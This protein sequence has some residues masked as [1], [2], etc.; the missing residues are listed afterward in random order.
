MSTWDAQRQIVPAAEW[1]GA[2]DRRYPP[3]AVVIGWTLLTGTVGL[4]ASVAWLLARNATSRARAAWTV[5]G[6]VLGAGV[7][8]GIVLGLTATAYRGPSERL[9]AA[10]VRSEVVHHFGVAVSSMTCTLPSTWSAGTT[11]TCYAYSARGLVGTSTETVAPSRGNDWY[12][13]TDWHPLAS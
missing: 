9:V 8:V 6:A 1:S 5:L 4:F 13:S 10:N 11:F 3:A 7:I 12:W 2:G